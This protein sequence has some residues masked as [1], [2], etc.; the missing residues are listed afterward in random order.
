MEE[1]VISKYAIVIIGG[2]PAGISTALHLAS[3][4]PN[5]IRNTIILEKAEYPRP[6]LC[7]GGLT[8]DAEILLKRLGLDVNEIPYRLAN[9]ASMIY[10]GKGLKLRP[11][12]QHAIKVIQ[13]YEFDHWLATKARERGILIQENTTVKTI[14]TNNGKVI[15][16]TDKGTFHSRVVVGADGS[17]GVTRNCFFPDK[18]LQAARLLEIRLKE[19]IGSYP[20]N[21]PAVFDFTPI[22]S[23][24][25]GYTWD[26]PALKDGVLERCTG[27][28]DNNMQIR[29]SKPALK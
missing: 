18:K 20:D 24:I 11:K 8:V 28:F 12:K 21:Y 6:K 3:I 25:A 14:H 4:A 19:E 22:S 1:A 7:G 15:V 13:R 27:I 9:S 16:E 26:F 5:L 23:G 17:N 29:R 10:K 2:G